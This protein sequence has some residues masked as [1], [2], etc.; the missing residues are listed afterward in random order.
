MNSETKSATILEDMKINVKIKLSALWVT[1]NLLYLYV[2]LYYN[3]RPGI[4]EKIMAGE[5]AFTGIEVTQAFLLVVI[6][7]MTIPS[8]MVFLSLILPAKANRWTN[9]IVGIFEIIFVIGAAIGETWAYYIFASIVEVVLLSLIVW[10]AWKWSKVSP[11]M[12]F[13]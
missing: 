6:I 11:K 8:I 13:S 1:V 10:Y 7:L 9:I 2:D 5:V 12:E 4:I 3:Y